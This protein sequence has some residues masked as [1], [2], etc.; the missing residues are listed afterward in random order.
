M[1][2]TTDFTKLLVRRGSEPLHAAVIGNPESPVWNPKA[3]REGILCLM[4]AGADPNAPRWAGLHRYIERYATT[5]SGT[6][7]VFCRSRS[8]S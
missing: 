1:T 4:H 2:T 5:S 6:Q 8:P 7:P 3:Q